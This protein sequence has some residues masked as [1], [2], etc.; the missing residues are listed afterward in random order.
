MG[1]LGCRGVKI[2]KSEVYL[3]DLLTLIS[4]RHALFIIIISTESP[5]VYALCLVSVLHSSY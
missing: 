2:K 5:Y 3:D 4:T 1:H